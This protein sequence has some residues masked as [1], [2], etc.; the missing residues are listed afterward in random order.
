MKSH[1]CFIVSPDHQW[2][3]YILT[4]A[5]TL[6]EKS[7][8]DGHFLQCSPP[9]PPPSPPP[10]ERAGLVVVGS[11]T[12]SADDAVAH[13]G[14]EEPPCLSGYNYR[15]VTWFQHRGSSTAPVHGG[16]LAS[17][18]PP[19]ASDRAGT[20]GASSGF[21]TSDRPEQERSCPPIQ[22]FSSG[23][24]QDSRDISSSWTIRGG[25]FQHGGKIRWP[26]RPFPASSPECSEPDICL[27]HTYSL[28]G[29]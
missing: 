12:A 15:E 27:P 10:H 11:I 4:A 17:P 18:S 9:L 19:G 16:D 7:W 20:R 29:W 13:T 25:V 1:N 2:E 8:Q 28:S 6:A 22:H 5:E 21:S 14:L 26:F 24:G 23:G 3:S